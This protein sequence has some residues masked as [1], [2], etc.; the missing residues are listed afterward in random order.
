MADD[1]GEEVDSHVRLIFHVIDGKRIAVAECNSY[2]SPVYFRDGNRR[3]LCIRS[4]NLTRSLDVASAIADVENH[5]KS[6]VGIT[7]EKI[8][9]RSP[10]RWLNVGRPS[11]SVN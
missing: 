4:G 11:S 3:E 1:L 10:M 8:R 6:A 9:A 7:E 2:P 5:W